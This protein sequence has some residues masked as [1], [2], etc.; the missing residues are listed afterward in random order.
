LEEHRILLSLQEMD[1]ER[2]EEFTEEQAPDLYSFDGRDLLAELEEL[3]ERVARVRA[4][5]PSRP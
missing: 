4:N 1:L 5:E 3:R 2:W